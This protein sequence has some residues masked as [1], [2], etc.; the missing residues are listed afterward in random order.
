MSGCRQ[1]L[2]GLLQQWGAL[3]CTPLL[4]IALVFSSALASAQAPWQ[5]VDRHDSPAAIPSCELLGTAGP[6][7]RDLVLVVREG[8]K[9]LLVLD[10][11]TL[12]TLGR[13][14]LSQTL[15]GTP[16][17]S[18]DGRYVYGYSAEGWV[19]RLDLQHFGPVLQTR[20]GVAVKALT[21]SADARWLLAG[22]TAPHHLLLLD[23][24]LRPV[25]AY[26]T[27]ALSGGP[28]SAVSG[29]WHSSARKSFMVA[30]ETLPELWE[31]SYDPAAEPVHDGLVHDYRMGEA[32]GSPGFLGVRRTPLEHPLAIL[33]GDATLR[34]LAAIAAPLQNDPS[35][36]TVS[37]IEIINMDIRRRI[38]TR[39]VA[40]SPT[41]GAGAEFAT[42]HGAWLV[43]ATQPEGRLVLIETANWRLYSEPLSSVRGVG[44]VRTHPGAP[45]LWLLASTT[46]SSD[47]L[48]LVDKATWR[49]ISTLREPGTVWTGIGF[50]ANGSQ[51]VLGA[52]GAHG[53]VRIV[54]TQTLREIRRVALPQVDAI[55]ALDVPAR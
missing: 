22:H 30:F 23:S 25:R 39:T 13:C 8:G 27:R 51:A 48:V 24:L 21:L 15:Q 28:D 2:L 35:P 1:R 17:R 42:P 34:H 4:F 10:P 19:L 47:T 54:D 7:S 18:P 36:S 50:T 31:L 40:G 44:M 33:M 11:A 14:H 9:Q 6:A 55:F 43:L 45:Q 53:G 37:E 26:R 41:A 32:V 46:A 49:V 3:R 12:L 38:A 20:I 29:I 5:N 16:L 52:R